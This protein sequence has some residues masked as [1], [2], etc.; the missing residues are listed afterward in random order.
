MPTGGIT[1]ERNRYRLQRTCSCWEPFAACAGL[2]ACGCAAAGAAAGLGLRTGARAAC[3][4]ATAAAA[5]AELAL[6]EARGCCAAGSGRLKAAGAPD[7][8]DEEP[9]AGAACRAALPFFA[10]VFQPSCRAARLT[11]EHEG[12]PASSAPE[13]LMLTCTARLL[14]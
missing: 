2:T 14:C 10:T 7:D 11:V 13:L 1:E 4:A 6:E 5:D 3:A 12:M 9:L 8:A